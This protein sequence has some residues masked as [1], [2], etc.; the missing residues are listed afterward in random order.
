M[1]VMKC[2]HG[3]RIDIYEC[4]LPRTVDNARYQHMKTAESSVD[5][6]GAKKIQ[7]ND[8]NRLKEKE[9]DE[10]EE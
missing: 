4:V 8:I 10:D 7:S 1:V 3:R 2:S 5:Q 9:K 6:T